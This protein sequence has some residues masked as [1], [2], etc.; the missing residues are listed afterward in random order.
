[1]KYGTI[2]S[3]R[4]IESHADCPGAKSGSMLDGAPFTKPSSVKIAKVA[5]RPNVITSWKIPLGLIPR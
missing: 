2:C 3:T 4:K 1:M 5:S